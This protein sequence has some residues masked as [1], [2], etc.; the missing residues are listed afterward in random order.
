[1]ALIGEAAQL[2]ERYGRMSAVE[3]VLQQA[4]MGDLEAREGMARVVY[5]AAYRRQHG[6]FD[7]LEANL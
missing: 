1:M 4:V 5:A 2:R 3:S 7:E 6:F